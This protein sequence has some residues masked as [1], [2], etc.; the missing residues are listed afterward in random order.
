MSDNEMIY[1]IIAPFVLGLL[2]VILILIIHSIA[3]QIEENKNEKANQEAYDELNSFNYFSGA[4]KYMVTL[5][6]GSDLDLNRIKQASSQVVSNFSSYKEFDYLV[7]Y[8]GLVINDETIY[9]LKEL[10]KYVNKAVRKSNDCDDKRVAKYIINYLPSFKMYYI[11]PQGKSS[12]SYKVVLTPKKISEL[13]ETIE[14]LLKKQET[15]GYQ[16]LK[17][18]SQMRDSILQRDN[19]TCKICGNSVYKEPN[20]LL[21]I[22]HII[23]VSKGG[24]T[25]PN[26]LQTLC[27]R[28]NRKKSD[29]I[30]Y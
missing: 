9:N 14:S 8:F 26:N 16:R 28:C 25:E 30:K 19:Y 29:N 11:S 3:N 24:K 6:G 5:F 10:K 1:M 17:L 7:K 18:T 12:T 15:S 22:D 4:S 20:L 13:I 27:W 23:P 21:E 2:I